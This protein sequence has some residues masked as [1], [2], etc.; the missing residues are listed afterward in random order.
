V[1]QHNTEKS[2]LHNRATIMRHMAMLLLL[3]RLFR[4]AM[5]FCAFQKM[6]KMITAE[7]RGWEQ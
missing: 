2:E 7:K 5:T 1:Q 4:D 6:Q 3:C